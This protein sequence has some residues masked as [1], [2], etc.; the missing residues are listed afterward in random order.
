MK[1]GLLPMG[2]QY[3]HLSVDEKTA[4]QVG[5]RKDEHPVIL[6]IASQKAY[7]AGITF[8]KGNEIVWLAD[9]VPPAFISY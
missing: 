4:L 9:K 6:K 5:R 8:Y 7:S 3:V 1:Q 2:R